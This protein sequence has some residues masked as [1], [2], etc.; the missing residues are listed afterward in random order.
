MNLSDRITNAAQLREALENEGVEET[1]NFRHCLQ[2]FGELTDDNFWAHREI[3]RL[4]ENRGD[5][6]ML[7][8]DTIPD[9]YQF[10]SIFRKSDVQTA[11]HFSSQDHR[12]LMFPIVTTLA[13]GE[14]GISY[15]PTAE[16]AKKDRRIATKCGRFYA[17][18]GLENEDVKLAVAKFDSHFKPRK[19]HFATT[20][21]DIER[22]YREGPNSCMGNKEFYVHP[23]RVYE[24]PDLAIA[25]IT[26]DNSP[27]GRITGRTVVR[28]DEGNE[29]FVRI[30][31]DE[32]R[33]YQALEAE[34]FSKPTHLRGT[35]LK[36]IPIKKLEGDDNTVFALPYIDGS[37]QTV[38]LQNIEDDFLT[39]I[40]GKRTPEGAALVRTATETNGFALAPGVERCDV[41]DNG[42]FYF[43]INMYKI[44]ARDMC[45]EHAIKFIAHEE[46]EEIRGFGHNQIWG[47]RNIND[48]IRTERVIEFDGAF[49]QNNEEVL[50]EYGLV[51][52]DGAVCHRDD[53]ALVE[54]AFSGQMLR[55]ENALKLK[56]EYYAKLPPEEIHKLKIHR[57]TGAL[58]YRVPAQHADK[59]TELAQFFNHWI[60]TFGDPA[61]DTEVASFPAFRKFPKEK[62]KALANSAT[63]FYT[64]AQFRY[65]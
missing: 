8:D 39:V 10:L 27:N 37:F 32:D 36:R 63:I 6:K 9:K 25:Y 40:D 51:I 1:A 56:G 44:S 22:V 43:P 16:Y 58:Y 60:R 62:R 31:G 12:R 45:R 5:Y 21:K 52:I 2:S 33:T 49:Y 18:L 19:L 3:M 11:R 30:Y 29:G 57:E 55:K 42:K 64:S 14:K 53:P 38:A 41:C 4:A 13:N 65:A 34:G 54:C 46:V 28:L 35:R 20:E 26:E 61:L 47:M 24:S 48:M 17:K 7:P 23:C 50:Q 15:F 59:C